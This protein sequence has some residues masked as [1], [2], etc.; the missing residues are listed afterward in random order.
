MAMHDNE[1]LLLLPIKIGSRIVPNRIAINS[2]ECNDADNDGN[3]TQATYDRYEKF[4]KGQAAFIDFE[5]I[6]VQNDYVSR[7]R[8]LS[9]MPHNAKPL[10][11]FVRHLKDINSDNILVLQ[12][13]HSGEISNPV[14]SKRCRVT[15]QPIYGYEDAELIGENEVEK[16]IRQF[17]EATKIAHASGADG[18]DLKFCHGYFGS[19]ILRPFNSHKWKYGGDWKSRRQFAFDLIERVVKAVNDPNFIVGSKLSMFEG[20]PGGQGTAGPDSSV[21]DLTES[22]DLIKGLEERGA[23]Y[24]LQT[25]GCAHARPL[26]Q[27]TRDIPDHAYFHQ[28]FQKVCKDN[29]KPET[30][31]IGS[32]YSIYRDGTGTKFLGVDPEKNSM[33]FWGNKNIRDGVV[34]MVCLGRQSL[35]DSFVAQK[36]ADGCEKDIKWCTICGNCGKLLRLQGNVGCPVYDPNYAKILKEISTE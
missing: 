3:P 2:V 20:F 26:S 28:Y 32:G 8:Q 7:D 18:V 35:A 30:V 1:N 25:A 23:A 21:M 10:E 9:I 4:F 24:I 5:S 13:T 15:E 19:Q 36:M 29:L 27:P 17:V 33:K 11:E 16:I 34:D 12:L 31:V 22:I 14:F 6:T